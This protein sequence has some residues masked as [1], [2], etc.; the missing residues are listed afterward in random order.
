MAMDRKVA[1]QLA[2][3]A[4]TC[5]ALNQLE[6]GK[7][8]HAAFTSFVDWIEHAEPPASSAA[9]VTELYERHSPWILQARKE[10]ESFA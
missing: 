2:S 10:L 5:F 8:E 6:W 1:E 9:V 4:F 3:L 7:H